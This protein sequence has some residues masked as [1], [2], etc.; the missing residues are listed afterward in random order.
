MLCL[1]SPSRRFDIRPLP[2]VHQITRPDVLP[3]AWALGLTVHCV[4]SPAKRLDI[5]PLPPVRQTTRPEFLPQ[6]WALGQGG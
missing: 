1:V 2:P 5:R 3:Q 4:V 6:A